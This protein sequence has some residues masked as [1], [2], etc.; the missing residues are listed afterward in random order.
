M[1]RSPSEARCRDAQ[2]IDFLR[3]LARR[4]VVDGSLAHA[5]DWSKVA[6]TAE[7]AYYVD[8]ASIGDSNGF[9]RVA[10]A[11][12]YAA[13]ER[14]GVRSRLIQYEVD[15]GAERLRSVAGSEH[16]EPMAQGARAHAWERQSEWLYVGA[17]T[18]T[19]V[20]SRSPYRSIVKAVCAR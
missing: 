16:S 10:V 6:E 15:C 12:S 4:I 11:Q 19:L 5:A 17:R 20:A 9:R 3:R 7:A 2:H 8:A 14:G 18:G 1:L 13:P